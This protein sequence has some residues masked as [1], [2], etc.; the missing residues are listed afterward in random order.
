MAYKCHVYVYSWQYNFTK[1]LLMCHLRPTR[2]M[3]SARLLVD[4]LPRY[5]DI[6]ARQMVSDINCG[7]HSACKRIM[8]HKKI[9]PFRRI[10]APKWKTL[11]LYLFI[12]HIQLGHNIAFK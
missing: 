3:L 7:H 2:L 11:L 9:P 8:V 4:I 1:E 5:V 10:F 6:E 12:H